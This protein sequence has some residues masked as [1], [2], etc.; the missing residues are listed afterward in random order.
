MHIN[1]QELYVFTEPASNMAAGSIG[2]RLNTKV[3]SM[4]YEN[5]Y[6]SRL[7][8]EVMIGVSK[9]LMILLMHI[10]LIFIRSI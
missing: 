6:T 5:D 1:A 9:K 7:D 2:L 8:P 4:K 10:H 3:F